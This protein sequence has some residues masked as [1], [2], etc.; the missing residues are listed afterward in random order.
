VGRVNNKNENKIG[1]SKKRNQHQ[2][3]IN[4]FWRTFITGDR[5]ATLL[6]TVK[7]CSVFSVHHFIGAAETTFLRFTECHWNTGISLLSEIQYNERMRM[8]KY[9]A[10]VVAIALIILLAHTEA[11]PSK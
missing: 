3:P 10:H 9:T 4:N 5:L 1:S 11:M 8:R 7:L 6:L 2:E